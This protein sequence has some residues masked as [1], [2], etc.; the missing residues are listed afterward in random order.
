[1][2]RSPSTPPRGRTSSR[3]AA[4]PSRATAPGCAR[5]T[6]F[7]APTW[8]TENDPRFR[9]DAARPADRDRPRLGRRLGDARGGARPDLPLDRRDQLRAGRDG[10]VLDLHRLV[11]RQPRLLVLGRLRPDR[12]DLVRG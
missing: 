4:W 9:L 8:A 5:T 6:P 1:M 3:S 11:A 12:R 2:R 10:D 7:D